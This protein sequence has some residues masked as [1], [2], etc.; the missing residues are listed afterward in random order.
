MLGGGPDRHEGLECYGSTVWSHR[1]S[2]AAGFCVGI[3]AAVG[4]ASVVGFVGCDGGAGC[5]VG[6][7]GALEGLAVVIA[8]DVVSRGCCWWWVD[9]FVCACL[10][11]FVA[12]FFS[13]F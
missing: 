9:G 7:G 4:L 1:Y 8:L 13:G 3:A 2:L 12:G 5:W 6:I 11:G 10:Q